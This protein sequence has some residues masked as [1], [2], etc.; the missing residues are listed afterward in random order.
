M[1]TIFLDWN[2]DWLPGPHPKTEAE[3]IEAAKKYNLHPYEY[4]PYDDDGY[5]YGDYPE[6]P[7]KGV[8]LRDPF[9]PYDNPVHKRNFNEPDVIIRKCGLW[10]IGVELLVK[11]DRTTDANSCRATIDISSRMLTRF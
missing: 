3:F 10:S 7:L 8:A 1:G 11:C 2:K 5:G 4:K 6:L 9:Y